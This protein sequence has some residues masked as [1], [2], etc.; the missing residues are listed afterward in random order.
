M[1][2][3]RDILTGRAPRYSSDSSSSP[4]FCWN[5]PD[6]LCSSLGNFL[7]PLNQLQCLLKLKKHSKEFSHIKELWELLSSILKCSTQVSPRSLCLRH[8]NKEHHGQPHHSAVHKSHLVLS[9]SGIPIKSTMDNP[10]TVQYTGLISGLADKA[11]S[12]VRDLD[13][14]NDLTFFRLRSRKHEIMV[15]PDKEYM[16]IV[17]QNTNQ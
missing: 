10:T 12:V 11:R 4:S 16:L 7:L 2:A 14:T 3:T 8:P 9:V 6:R 15:A 17:V 13:P 1:G 5:L